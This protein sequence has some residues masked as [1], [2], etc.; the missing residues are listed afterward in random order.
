MKIDELIAELE[1]LKEAEDL[2]RTILL[3]CGGYGYLINGMDTD[4]LRRVQRF[5]GFDDNE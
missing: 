4:T 2:L 3:N 5:M 1:R